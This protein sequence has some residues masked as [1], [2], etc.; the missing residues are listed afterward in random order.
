[1]ENWISCGFRFGLAQGTAKKIYFFF[2]C[3][4][5]FSGFFWFTK[6]CI[7]WST[8]YPRRLLTHC[9]SLRTR[10]T[11]FPPISRIV[12]GHIIRTTIRGAQILPP[13]K[14]KAISTFSYTLLSLPV[15]LF[16][17]A[18]F[19]IHQ[20]VIAFTG[21]AHFICATCLTVVVWTFLTSLWILF[22]VPLWTSSHTFPV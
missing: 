5:S 4:F 12:E 1:M 19:I 14:K 7:A 17:T 6:S 9:A 13:Q 20:V 10:H 15:L 8:V 2:W 22:K 21:C 16:K 3:S 11:F 18:G